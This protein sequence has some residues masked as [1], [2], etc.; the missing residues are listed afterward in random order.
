MFAPMLC[1]DDLTLVDQRPADWAWM[2]K[3]DGFRA[4][5]HTRPAA[6]WSRTGN[7]LGPAFPDALAAALAA[8]PDVDAVLDCELVVVD[9]T[10]RPD[11][12]ALSAR[13]GCRSAAAV[14]SAA[15]AAP[16]LLLAFDVLVLDGQDL[17][18]MPWQ[19]RHDRLAQLG[20]STSV[21][22]GA[23]G[24]AY[25]QAH[26]D[27]PALIRAT[28]DLGLEGVVAKHRHSP[29]VGRRSNTWVK[30]KHAHARDLNVMP[31]RCR[32]AR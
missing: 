25:L 28:H 2:V 23:P 10:A 4:Q 29:Y 30:V 12:A 31:D 19:A 15:T 17:R 16:A 24:V 11:F 1:G 20:L 3:A 18:A 22:P 13:A 9:D 14:R 7:P 32:R 27:G 5:L 6:L 21:A 26:D 8:L